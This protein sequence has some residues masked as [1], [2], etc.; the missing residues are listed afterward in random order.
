MPREAQAR[1]CELLPRCFSPRADLCSD[2]SNGAPDVLDL[3]VSYVVGLDSGDCAG[4]L[5]RDLLDAQLELR[6]NGSEF[7]EARLQQG[8]VIAELDPDANELRS[9]TRELQR[10]HAISRFNRAPASICAAL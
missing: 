4:N 3:L 8:K 10:K 5:C 9:Q 2:A 1:S 7:G 6:W